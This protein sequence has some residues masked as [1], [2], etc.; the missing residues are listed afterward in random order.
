MD[1]LVQLLQEK[2]GINKTQAEK[3]VDVVV[4]F[5]KDKLPKPIA[6]QLDT[7]LKN[8]DVMDQVADVAEKGLGA[9]GGLLNKKSD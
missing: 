7:V 2:T 5:L 8:E 6:G 3:A 9:L 1:E 4:K